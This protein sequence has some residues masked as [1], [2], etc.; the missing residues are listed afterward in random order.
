[1]EMCENERRQQREPKI[2]SCSAVFD[3][4]AQDAVTDSW[5]VHCIALSDENLTFDTDQHSSAELTQ[6]HGMKDSR[7][8]MPE[9]MTEKRGK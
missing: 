2:Q 8:D 5:G 9:N 3:V 7:T 4:R 6:L 1:M